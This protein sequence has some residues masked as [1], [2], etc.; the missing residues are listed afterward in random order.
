MYEPG[1]L[2]AAWD[3][4]KG[5]DTETR[6]GLRVAASVSALQGEA[7]GVRLLD[8]ARQAVELSREGLRARARKGAGLA[9][10]TGY[11]D[12]LAESV[13]SGRVQADKLLD[14]YHG[15]WKQSMTP[16]YEAVSY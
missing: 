1:A 5:F 15:P 14:L 13:A 16:V 11:L 4:V 7:G 2:D 3:L 9:D 6:E 10:E 8:L 12:V